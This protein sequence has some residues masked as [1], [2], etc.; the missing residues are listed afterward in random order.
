MPFW[1]IPIF[2]H[3]PVANFESVCANTELEI[4]NNPISAIK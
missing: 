3:L 2:T 4:Q 1:V